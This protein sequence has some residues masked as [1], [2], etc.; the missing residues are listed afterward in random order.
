MNRYDGDIKINCHVPCDP[1]TT[2]LRIRNATVLALKM[3]PLF[4]CLPFNEA[5]GGSIRSQDEKK[6]KKQKKR[7]QRKKKRKHSAVCG[8]VTTCLYSDIQSVSSSIRMIKT[9]VNTYE[10]SNLFFS[11]PGQLLDVGVPCCD[12]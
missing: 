10:I 8:T 3:P 11:I 2:Q 6:Q 7:K 1:T 12:P 5:V 4:S 9:K